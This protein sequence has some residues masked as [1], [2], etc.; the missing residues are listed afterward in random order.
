MQAIIGLLMY[1]VKDIK[2]EQPVLEV[3]TLAR[4]A[5]AAAGEMLI[6]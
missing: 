6:Q 2:A 5:L 4:R 1:M 3:T